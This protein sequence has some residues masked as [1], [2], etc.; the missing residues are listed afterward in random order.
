[1]SDLELR[2][3]PGGVR[4]DH[5]PS[6]LPDMCSEAVRADGRA[7]K[8]GVPGRDSMAVGRNW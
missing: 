2:P 6:E 1:M 5:L 3:Q 4:C 8:S 7:G